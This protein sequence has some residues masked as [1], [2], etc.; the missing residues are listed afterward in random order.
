MFRQ[1]DEA[2]VAARQ[3]GAAALTYRDY[4]HPPMLLV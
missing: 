2:M 4:E 3:G 1:A